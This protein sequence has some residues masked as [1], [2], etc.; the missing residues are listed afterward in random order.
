MGVIPNVVPLD[1]HP[2]ARNRAAAD[3]SATAALDLVA[4]LFEQLERD[5]ALPAAVRAEIAR[6][7]MPTLRA[8]QLA[9]D[10]LARRAHPARRLLD[11][12]GAAALG[13]D[14]TADGGDATVAAIAAAVHDLLS[15]FDAELAPFD[16]AADRLAGFLA[17]RTRAEDEGARPLIQAIAQREAADAP[18]RAAQEEVVR[19]LRARLWVPAPVRTMLLGAWA[20]ALAADYREHG[21]GSAV[22]HERVRTMDDLLWSVE[23]KASPEGRRRLGGILPALIQALV[24]GLRRAEAGESER[25]DFLSAL[26][27]CHAHA[28]RS[29]LRGLSL[30]PDPAGGVQPA[31][32]SLLR[33][34]FTVGER[35]VEDIRLAAST[36]GDAG[37]AEEAVARLRLGA[38]VELERG[39]RTAARKRLAWASPVTGACLFVGLAPASAGV[40]VTLDALAEQ[41]RRGEARIVDD[42]PLVER[43]LAALVTRLAPQG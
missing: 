23:P 38:G 32:P 31:A 17:A 13:L 33:S 2:R 21:E 37:T 22:W 36:G 18:R 11:A 40:A 26:V 35:R 10:L 27:D 28:M 20:R 41:V 5:T 42:A 19:R 24:Q 9:P 7:R 6:L 14:E 4:R 43:T 34:T 39:A 12:I 30:V 3:A 1:S 25:D 8:T 29:G 15:G 16:A